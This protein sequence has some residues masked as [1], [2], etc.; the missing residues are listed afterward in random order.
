MWKPMSVLF[1]RK[2]DR[3]AIEDAKRI[4]SHERPAGNKEKAGIK[5]K[6]KLKADRK[7]I[8]KLT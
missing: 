4:R 6:M 7:D 2:R 1:A 8:D 5:R 3:P